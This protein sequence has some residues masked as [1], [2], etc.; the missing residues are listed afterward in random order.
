MVILRYRQLPPIPW[1]LDCLCSSAL[2]CHFTNMVPSSCTPL[3][4]SCRWSDHHDLLVCWVYR[5]GG[6]VASA[7]VVSWECMQLAPGSNGIWG[8]WMVRIR[9]FWAFGLMTVCINRELTVICVAYRV[10][11][12]VTSYFGIVDLMHHRRGG[13]AKPHSNVN[14]GVWSVSFHNLPESIWEHWIGYLLMFG[15]LSYYVVRDGVWMRY[16]LIATSWSSCFCRPI[17]LEIGFES[18]NKTKD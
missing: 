7:E 18:S 13:E 8:F 5:Y 6:D 15:M 10:L 17:L 16:P 4:D 1:L 9:V 2:P 12:A 14:I 11:F 3:C